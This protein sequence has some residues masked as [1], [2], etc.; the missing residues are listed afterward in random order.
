MF[1]VVEEMALDKPPKVADEFALPKIAL[2]GEKFH[3]ECIV[4]GK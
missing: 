2:K 1:S 3:L 4:Y